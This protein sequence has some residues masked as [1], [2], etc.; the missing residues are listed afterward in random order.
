MT[1]ELVYKGNLLCELTH[2]RSGTKIMTDAP[3]DNQGNGS[4]FSPTDL[5]TVAAAACA[6]T[7]VGI[8]A[9]NNGWKFEGTTI[10]VTKIMASDPRRVAEIVLDVYWAGPALSEDD[11]QRVERIAL[12]CPVFV[13]LHPDV[14]KTVNFNWPK[15]LATA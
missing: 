3:V 14:K 7:T 1:A 13:S 8:A 12:N 10:A 6:M 4:A 2:E 9:R 5:L 11:K 15:G